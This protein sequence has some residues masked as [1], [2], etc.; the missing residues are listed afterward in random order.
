VQHDEFETGERRL[1]NFGHTLGHALENQY[2][3]MHGHAV[4][5]GMAYASGISA[6]LNGFMEAG[7]VKKVLEQFDLPVF[8]DF[9]KEK[10]FNVMKMDKKREKKDMN[11][12]MLSRIGRGVVKTVP[13]DQLEKIINELS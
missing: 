9:E 5:I 2:S 13:V 6:R 10:V 11:F 1:L 7:R 4:A 3:L 8:M 12:V